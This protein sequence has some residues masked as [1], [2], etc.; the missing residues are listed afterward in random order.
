MRL[1]TSLFLRAILTYDQAV[2][3]DRKIDPVRL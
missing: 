2:V 3:L 1:V